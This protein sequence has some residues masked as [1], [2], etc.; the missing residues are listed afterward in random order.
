MILLGGPGAG[1]GPQAG[2]LTQRYRIPPIS[3]GDMRR[4]AVKAGTPL[5]IEAQKVMDRG[6]LVSDGTMIALVKER[7]A[8]PDC[9][10][11][12]LLDGFP[13]TVPQAEALESI[14]A[15]R[16][17]SLDAAVSLRVPRDAIVKRLAGRRT[18]VGCGSMYHA[19]FQP[20][21]VDGVCDKCGGK[22][23]QRKD[24]REETI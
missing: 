11:G 12:F 7:L 10:R 6:E 21:R 4:A 1:K 17:T 13:R 18:C 5:G 3:P 20:P 9:A 24:D 23:E 14:L 22:L 8:A 16:K 19:A 15:K 2:Y